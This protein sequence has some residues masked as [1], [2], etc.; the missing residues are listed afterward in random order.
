VGSPLINSRW[1]SSSDQVFKITWYP[2]RYLPRRYS[3]SGMSSLF[4]TP[5]SH[6]IV[7]S[8]VDGNDLLDSHHKR[9]YAYYPDAMARDSDYIRCTS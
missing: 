6:D 8:S 1:W 4:I 5:I 7:R 9:I 2:I 3:F